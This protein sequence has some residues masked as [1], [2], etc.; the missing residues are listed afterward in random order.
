MRAW[1]VKGGDMDPTW[2]KDYPRDLR[3]FGRHLPDPEWPGGAKIA[4]T[5]AVN[6]EAGGELSILHGDDTSEAMLTDI[7]FPEVRGARSMLAESS[8][9]YGSR[10]GI[11]RLLDAFEDRGLKTSILA[12]ASGLSHNLELVQACV[13][14][15]HELV[16]HGWRWI[17]YQH[18]PVDIECEHIQLAVEAIES[19][20]GKRP[21]GW[22]TGRPGPNTRQL[23][24]AEGGF[25]YDRDTLNDELPYW[26]KDGGHLAVP[27]SYET[28]DN[29][30]NEN[31]GFNTAD[32]FFTYMRDA[33]D[34]L[35]AEG[36]TGQ[37]RM[38]SVGLHDRLIGRPGRVQGLTRF[39]D[40][41]LTHDDIWIATGEEIARHWMSVHPRPD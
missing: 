39:L 3:G 6:Y 12:V 10:R 16:S 17:D 20:T 4:V 36:R 34:V 7:G 24:I 40:Y 25:L 21:V 30:F 13:D 35:L 8:F 31:S 1:L 14:G 26:P 18:V 38:M 15:G 11:W 5:F 41:I 33:F 9:E 37:P 27:Y 32:D 29:R 28:N 2:G 23:L 19:L 22:M